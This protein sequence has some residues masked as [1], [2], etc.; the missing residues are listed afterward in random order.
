MLSQHAFRLVVAGSTPS[1]AK[2]KLVYSFFHGGSL[3]TAALLEED[4]QEETDEVV[5]FTVK[6][7][8]IKKERY[9]CLCFIRR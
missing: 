3:F 6:N 8:V 4:V 5:A 7:L 1:C 2:S 9:Q